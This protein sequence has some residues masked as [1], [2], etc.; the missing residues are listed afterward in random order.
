VIKV[1]SREERDGLQQFLKEKGVGTGIHYP[2][3]AHLQKAY[4]WLGLEKGSLPKVEDT[5]DRILS[6]PMF[7]ELPLEQ[8]EQVCKLIQSYRA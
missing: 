4:S 2:I 5:A 7:P 8:V 1:G 3:P 6:L